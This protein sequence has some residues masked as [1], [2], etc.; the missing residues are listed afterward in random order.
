MYKETLGAAQIKT[1][2]HEHPDPQA[3]QPQNCFQSLCRIVAGQQLAG[4]AARTVWLRL[5]D[6]TGCNLNPNT[7]L[8]LASKGFEEHL[9]KP[10]GLSKAKAR[11]IMALAEAFQAGELRDMSITDDHTSSLSEAFLTTAEDDKVRK[12]LLS[13]KGIGP[14]SCDM[15]MMFYLERPNVLPVGDLGVRK[16]IAKLFQLRGKGKQS[17]LCPKKDAELID[18][19]L[20]V[21]KP[22]SSLVSYY[23]WKVADTRDVYDN[24]TNIQI[25]AAKNTAEISGESTATSAST[26]KKPRTKKTILRQVT[27]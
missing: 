19:T 20:A 1:C 2:R 25:D 18:K 16:G 27:P 14:W 10:A 13:I 22:Y 15:F 8:E 24:S 17:S 7:I 4:A 6:V 21:Y 26:P 23:M 3:D 9:Q 5:L 11:S 12:A